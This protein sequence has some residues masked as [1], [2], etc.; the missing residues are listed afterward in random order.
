MPSDGRCRRP[1]VTLFV[2]GSKVV[3]ATVPPSAGDVGLFAAGKAEFHFDDVVIV[4]AKPAE[5][6]QA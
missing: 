1:T 6:D 2:D 3:S 4:D 5:R